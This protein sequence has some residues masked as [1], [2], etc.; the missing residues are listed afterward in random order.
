[1]YS[2]T[3]N[4]SLPADLL[5]KIDIAAAENY[6]SRSEYI[7]TAVVMRLND[8]RI[9]NNEPTPIEEATWEE[10]FLKREEG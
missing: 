6:A 5:E 8:Q 4:I 1:M 9:T 3:I 10:L 7:R 2:K